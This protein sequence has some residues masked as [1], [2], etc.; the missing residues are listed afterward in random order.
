MPSDSAYDTLPGAP[1]CSVSGPLVHSLAALRPSRGATQ[2]GT[3]PG[4]HPH[5]LS[6]HMPQCTYTLI[7]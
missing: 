7:A 4:M 2:P 1:A 5:S 3:H 6:P